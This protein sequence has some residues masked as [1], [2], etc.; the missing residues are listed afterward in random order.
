MSKTVTLR[1]DDDT[2][3]TF[4]E[5]AEDEKRSLSKFIEHAVIDYTKRSAFA[6]DEEMQAIFEDR[7]LVHRLK[8]G[9]QD[10]RK[11]RGRFAA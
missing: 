5:R 7:G 11:R 10:A 8:E 3:K 2:Y 1:V 6:D 9:I 4:V